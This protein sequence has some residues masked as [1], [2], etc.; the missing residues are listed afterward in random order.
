MEKAEFEAEIARLAGIE[1]VDYCRESKAAA[2]QL[3]ITK[4]EQDRCVKDA[5]RKAIDE[6]SAESE[7]HQFTGIK[8]EI[9]SDLEIARLCINDMFANDGRYVFSEG[10][11]YHWTGRIWA[12]LSDVDVQKRFVSRY[13]GARYG[14]SGVIR[15]DQHKA[16]SIIKFIAQEMEIGDYFQDRPLG[17]NCQNGFVIF[18]KDGNVSLIEHHPASPRAL[19]RAACAL[20]V[21]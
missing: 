6:Q 9:G 4:R 19:S 21:S 11:F 5:E 2:K 15:L 18:D 16:K 8:L 14:G 13:D 3:G 10:A 12:E 7:V 20:A 1:Y 17:V